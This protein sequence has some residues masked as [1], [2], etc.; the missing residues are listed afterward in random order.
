VYYTYRESFVVGM[1]SSDASLNSDLELALQI[2][3]GEENALRTF[4]AM[5]GPRVRAH[6]KKK[7]PQ[8]ADEAWQAAL[9][10][11]MQKANLYDP[12]Q[13]SLGPWFLRL[14]HRCAIS[15]LRA[16]KKYSAD[17]I[18]PDTARDMRRLEVKPLSAKQRRHLEARALQIREAV[19]TLPPKD[20]RVIE[21][22]LAHWLGQTLPSESAPAE[23]LAM[24]WGV[25][26][27][28]IYQARNRARARL[29]EELTRRGIFNEE[30]RP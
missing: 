1:M 16:E 21:A 14:A 12:A 11:L 4:I 22:D 13:G 2:A 8:I 3:C 23:K 17:Q 28:S 5:H 30:S 7:F 15:I 27:N 20:R 29:R 18:L 9:I 25:S 24:Q 6:L 10:R 26:A 19:N